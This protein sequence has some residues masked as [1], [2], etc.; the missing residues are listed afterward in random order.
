MRN[1]NQRGP[2]GYAGLKNLGCICYMNAMNQQLYNTE[3]F[4]YM[5]L[6]ANDNQP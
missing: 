1:D 2:Y 5:I 4:R 3:T 6:M